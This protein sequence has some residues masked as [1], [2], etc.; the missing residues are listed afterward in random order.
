MEP[1]SGGDAEADSAGERRRDEPERVDGQEDEDGG[2]SKAELEKR[3]GLAPCMPLARH[4]PWMG[5]S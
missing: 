2:L 1:E 3:T 5:R 4:R